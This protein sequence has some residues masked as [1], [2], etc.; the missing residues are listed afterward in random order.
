MLKQRSLNWIGYLVISSITI[1]SHWRNTSI[2]VFEG[3]LALRNLPHV[4]AR[5]KNV[6]HRISLLV[7]KRI[8][9]IF[10]E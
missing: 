7:T 5:Y 6:S 3:Q 2:A 8:L 10:S 9:A 1:T 4:E